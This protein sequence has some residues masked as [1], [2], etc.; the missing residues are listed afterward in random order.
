MEI[1]VKT[2]TGKT[3]SLEAEPS[4][5]IENAKT[6]L[7]DKEGIP[8]DQQCRIFAGLQQEDGRTLCYFLSRRGAPSS[9]IMSIDTADLE[10]LMYMARSV[11]E[12]SGYSLKSLTRA[13]KVNS[14]EQTILETSPRSSLLSIGNNNCFCGY[15]GGKQ[16]FKL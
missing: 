16:G 8:P 15:F 10:T 4:D 12:R 6:K 9:F 1:F 14:P 5:T 13:S 11:I 3:I 7:Q 2:L